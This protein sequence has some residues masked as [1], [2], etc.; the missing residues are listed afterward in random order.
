MILNVGLTYTEFTMFDLVY[1]SVEYLQL[2]GVVGALRCSHTTDSESPG[3]E[4][5]QQHQYPD[6]K[7]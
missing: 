2:V 6:R 1:Y 5:T 3:C 4:Q 7:C